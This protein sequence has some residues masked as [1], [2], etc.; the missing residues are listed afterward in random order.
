M[1]VSIHD[2]CNKV[3]VV[4]PAYNAAKTIRKTCEQIDRAVVDEIIVVDDYSTDETRRIT[5]DLVFRM[6]F[7]ARI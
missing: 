6:P 1:G 4:C 2:P 3:C 7:T 5:Q